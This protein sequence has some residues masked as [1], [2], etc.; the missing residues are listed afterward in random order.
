ML[1]INSAQLRP[2]LSQPATDC[3]NYEIGHYKFVS[4]HSGICSVGIIFL[5][6]ILV[7][8]LS[9]YDLLQVTGIDTSCVFELIC[10][11]FTISTKSRPILS[12]C[13][14]GA[15]LGGFVSHMFLLIFGRV[16]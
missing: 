2:V 11:Q 4:C 8:K 16:C 12:D 6:H 14:V 1:V 3:A 15:T 5:I 9:G 10:F 7:W 13:I